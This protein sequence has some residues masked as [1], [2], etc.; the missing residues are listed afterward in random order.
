M[1]IVNNLRLSIS[2]DGWLQYTR[3]SLYNKSHRDIARKSNACFMIRFVLAPLVGFFVTILF[4]GCET[5][6][7]HHELVETK[8]APTNTVGATYD[9]KVIDAVQFHWM[10]LLDTMSSLS[11][12]TNGKVVIEFHLHADGNVSD[13]RVA[14]STTDETTALVCQKAVSESAPFPPWPQE[15]RRAFTNDYRDLHFTFY[16]DSR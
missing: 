15:M 4:S 13:L 2:S 7:A 12:T 14:R 11:T 16:I 5:G 6:G 8:I 1:L 9:V 10:Q 3:Q